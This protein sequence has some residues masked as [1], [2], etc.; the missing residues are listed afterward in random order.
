MKYNK[1]DPFNQ[2]RSGKTAKV[3]TEQELAEQ[4]AKREQSH[5]LEFC[6]WIKNTYPE[7]RFRSDMQAGQK[8]SGYMQNLVDILDPFSGWPDVSIW[9]NRGNYCGLMIEMKR[10]NSGAILK[11]GSLSKGKHVQN[12]HQ[13]HEFLRG[14][15]WKV[16]IAEGCEEAKKVLDSY[17]KLQ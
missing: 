4:K 16:E 2:F 3:V 7:I 8:R 12:Q 11:D 13:V 9:V 10:E 5:Q 1:H 14:L 15:G 6:K 17:L